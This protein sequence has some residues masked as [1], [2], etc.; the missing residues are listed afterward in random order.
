MTRIILKQQENNKNK[1]NSN[2]IIIN[3]NTKAFTLIELLVVIA[4]IGILTALAVVS[5]QNL[6]RSARD[7][8]RV[9]D[10]K[11]L[12]IALELYY[13]DNNTYPATLN[14][15]ESL[16]SNSITYMEQIPYPPT[17]L[18][19]DC[20]T[21][22]YIYSTSND[23]S[24]Y[25]INFC[26]SN[27][28]GSFPAGNIAASPRGLGTWSCGE[29]L[30][31]DRDNQTYATMQ[32]G[33]QCWFVENLN[34]GTMI[35]GSNTSTNENTDIEKYCYDDNESNCDIYG[36]LYQWSEAMNYNESDTQGIC[37]D[38]WHIPTSDDWN[39]FILYIKSNPNYVCNGITNN[40]GKALA[41]TFGWSKYIDDICDVSNDQPN[42]NSSGFNALTTGARN[43]Q[44]TYFV[45]RGWGA[46]FW[47]SSFN[48]NLVYYYSLVCTQP[49][50][51][52]NANANR[53]Y[54]YSIRC[55]K[56]L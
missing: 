24:Y 48:P 50:F 52:S 8:K 7:A 17:N 10:V 22:S 1:N 5:L 6:R 15:G 18:D 55:L 3:N 44:T 34:V 28:V 45:N 41:S 38:G 23:N 32:Y 46:Y 49:H 40:I 31:D 25:T 53:S 36:G 9:A 54:G 26:I 4:I 43:I 2:N 42:N 11:Q 16:S 13:Q 35:N 33:E 27:N 21:T 20:S 56:D 51:F 12:Q 30:L 37:P 29:I 39:E 19:G 47:S 14:P